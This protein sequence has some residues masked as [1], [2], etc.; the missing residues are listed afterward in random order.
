MYSWVYYKAKQNKAKFISLTTG[1]VQLVRHLALHV[2]DLGLI[3][4][5]LYGLFVLP[6]V[7]PMYRARSKSLA[8]L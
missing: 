8:P 1:I 6:G 5:T 4:R 3:P 2:A 7:I